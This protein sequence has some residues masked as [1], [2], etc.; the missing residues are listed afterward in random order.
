MMQKKY[1]I[2][3]ALCNLKKGSPFMVSGDTYE[4]INWM[5]KTTPMPTEKEIFDE[6]EVLM[7]NQLKATETTIQQ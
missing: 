6:V 5:D 3:T 1:L 4:S 7:L 2:A